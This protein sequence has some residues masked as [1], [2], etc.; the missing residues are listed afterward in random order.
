MTKPRI[1]PVRLLDLYR[2]GMTD[3]AIAL[4]LGCHQTSV[5]Y[6]RHKAK[7]PA[8]G[9]KAPDG[10]TIKLTDADKR[11]ARKMLREGATR[12]QVATALGKS[13]KT[14]Q[15][16]RR[17]MDKDERLRASGRPQSADKV[18][19]AK[20]AR[21]IMLEL[22]QACRG[23]Q[24]TALRDDAVSEMFLALLEG[25]LKRDR[26]KAEARTFTGRAIGLWASRYGPASLDEDMTGEGFTLGDLIPCPRAAAWLEAVG[27]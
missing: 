17:T 23:L 7:L 11:L 8:N 12:K 27:A 18:A 13:T 6:W 16:L 10:R 26:I 20:D 24:D 5:L 3:A 22:A 19:V 15:N 4:E 2:Q 21:A 25:R 9:G 1:D 14:I